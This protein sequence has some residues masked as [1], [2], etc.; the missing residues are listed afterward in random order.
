MK[1][2]NNNK[3]PEN[4]VLAAFYGSL[5]FVKIKQCLEIGKILFSFVELKNPKN[6]IDCYMEAEEFG[7]ILM[8]SVKNGSLIKNLMAEKAKGE[9]Y[10]KAVWTSPIGGNATGNSGKPI[11]RYFEIS[12]AAK[13]EVLFTAHAF[14][15]EKNDK[16]AF[17]KQR[18]AKALLTLRIPCTYNDLRI[19]QYKWSFLE[20]DYMG[21]KYTVAN[22]KSAYQP[23]IDDTYTS[24]SP[25][26]ED[27]QNDYVE[28]PD[29]DV[30]SVGTSS[31]EDKKE[32]KP[33][34]EAKSAEEKT[35]QK[36]TKTASTKVVKL[37]ATSELT[38]LGDKPIKVCKVLLD[39]EEKRL[40]CMTDKFVDT[41][42]F[43][44]FEKQLSAQVKKRNSLEFKGEIAEKGNDLYLCKFA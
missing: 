30:P 35:D 16:G 24:A 13:G 36:S 2:T 43:S 10:P 17:I 44:Q 23:N 5:A 4:N 34:A 20:A 11:S 1:N 25:I 14:P 41:D 21:N 28:A 39:N 38:A 32:V 9:Q 40:I 12:P 19:L 3:A 15:A 18:G 6:N 42:K 8:A 29:E 26:P 22:M 7:A 33:S 37:I 27:V 31:K